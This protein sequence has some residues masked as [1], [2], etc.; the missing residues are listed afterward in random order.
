MTY[1]NLPELEPAWRVRCETCGAL[2]DPDTR[3]I[4]HHATEPMPDMETLHEWIIDSVCDAT[5]GCQ[6]EPDGR[7]EHG[8]QSWLLR[9]GLI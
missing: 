2:A 5:D 6:V 7:C 4:R 8:H 9:L 1:V 3:K